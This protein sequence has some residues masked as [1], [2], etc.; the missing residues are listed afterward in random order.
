[1]SSIDILH[2]ILENE[3]VIGDDVGAGVCEGSDSED[4]AD[5]KDF[6]FPGQVSGLNVV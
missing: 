3:S 5:L 1:M 6:N 4:Y 2:P